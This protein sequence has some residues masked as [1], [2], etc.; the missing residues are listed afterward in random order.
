M[1]GPGMVNASELAGEVLK[2]F[3]TRTRPRTMNRH[4]NKYRILF[5]SVALAAGGEQKQLA[6]ILKNLDRRVYEPVVCCIRPLKQIDEDIRGLGIPT[7]SLGIQNHWNLPPI[8]RGIRRVIKEYDIDLVQLGIF[9]SDFQ[10]LLAAISMGTPSVMILQS[11]FDLPARAQA[12]KSSGFAWYC[13]W[14][15]IYA[16]HAILA[17]MPK[18]HYVALSEA[19]K[20]SAIRELRLPEKRVTVVPLGLAPGKFNVK[21]SPEAVARIKS[22]LLTADAYPVLLN[23]GRLSAVKGQ[24][25]LLEAMPEIIKRF[26]RARLLIAGD[27]PLLTELKRLRDHL[28]LKKEVLLLGHRDDV[29]ALLG[30]SN[31]FVFSSYYEGLPGAV[32]EAMAAG[33]PVVAFDIPSLREIVKDGETGILVPERNISK[34]AQSV[35]RLAELPDIARDMGE[36][37]RQMVQTKYD[38]HQNIKE[39]EAVFERMLRHLNGQKE[40]RRQLS[41]V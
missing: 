14:R 17:R 20:Q 31:M 27:G 7:L 2:R 39:L 11:M 9:G 33:K 13:K 35:I 5:F 8:I 4:S 24:R 41:R 28:N 12:E 23:V 32:I 37:G 34:F 40:R 16:A 29:S 18:I 15:G 26:P 6:Q 21:I 10:G 36:R 3:R 38:I 30:V 22:Q 1:D 25:D 19:V